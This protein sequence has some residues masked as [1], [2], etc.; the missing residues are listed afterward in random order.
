MPAR[1]GRRVAFRGRFFTTTVARLGPYVR[2]L[3]ST[4]ARIL[5]EIF[6][7]TVAGRLVAYDDP[8]VGRGVAV[9]P[10]PPLPRGTVVGLYFGSL[11]DSASTPR[12]DYALD[13][14]RLRRGGRVFRLSVDAARCCRRHDGAAPA[15]LNAAMLNHTCWDASVRLGR[16]AHCPFP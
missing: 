16:P 6:D 4:L 13:L 8:L 14:G 3:E 15:L 9:A 11:V 7:G 5:P 10:G 2:D 12:G 1:R